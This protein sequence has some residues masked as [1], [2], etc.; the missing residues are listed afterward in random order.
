MALLFYIIGASGAGKDSLMQ[1]AR[2]TINGSQPLIFAHRYITRP[3]KDGD[4]NHI[5]LSTEEFIQRRDRGALA[6]H[7]ESHDLYYGIGKE[8]DLWMQMGCSVVVNGSRAYLSEAMYHYPNL[9]PVLIEA[10]PDIIRRRLENRGRETVADIEKRI[11]RKPEITDS[12]GGA[13]VIWNNGPLTQGGE[14]LITLLTNHH[15]TIST[16]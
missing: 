16:I 4:E 8:I 5:Y 14:A 13:I 3:P 15:A 12:S 6:L 2:R 11:Q 9:V 7:W 10:D 1:Y